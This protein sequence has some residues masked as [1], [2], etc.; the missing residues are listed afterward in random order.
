MMLPHIFVKQFFQA[1]IRLNSFFELKADADMEQVMALARELADKTLVEDGCM[2][3]D[4]MQSLSN[5][6]AMMFC[7]TWLSEDH[8]KAHSLTPHFGR[9]VPLIKSLT[10]NGTRCDKFTF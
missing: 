8:L 9:L 10:V 3:Y 2:G 4:V 5:R 6:R 1:M 7:E